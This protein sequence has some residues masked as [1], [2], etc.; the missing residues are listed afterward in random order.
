MK[1]RHQ[2][3]FGKLTISIL[4]I[5]VA[6]VCS[7]RGQN[8]NDYKVY[9]AVI[10]HMFR[11]GI[12]QFDMNAK[13]DKIV[14]RDRTFSEYSSHVEKEN[15]PQ[16]KIRLRSLTDETVGG[17][18]AARIKENEFKMKLDIPFK[19]ILLTNKQLDMVFPDRNYDG[20]TAYW[21]EFYRLYPGSGG[22]NSFSK[23]G[24]DKSGR[25][26]LV[27]FV[28]RCGSHCGTGTYVL[29]EKSEGGWV[30]KETAMM[31]IS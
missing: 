15:W 8:Q 10:R 4:T 23:V 19:Y 26:A 22:Y 17:Y 20:L 25:F 30:V 14:I 29:V 11:D 6:T 28:N 24:Y 31:W 7:V 2:T 12:T 9:D 27:Y 3:G 21:S 13:I 16:V 5:M 18:A 1:R